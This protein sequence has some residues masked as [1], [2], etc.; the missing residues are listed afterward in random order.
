MFNSVVLVT[1]VKEISRFFNSSY[2]LGISKI[3]SFIT[4][5]HTCSK[6]H[7]VYIGL[8]ENS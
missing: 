6:P 4:Y 7:Y 3:S 5:I 2:Y 1:T 8:L